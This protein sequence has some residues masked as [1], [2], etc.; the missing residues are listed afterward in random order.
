[1]ITKAQIRLIH[2][3][4]TRLGIEDNDYR[5]ILWVVA[6]VFSSKDLDQAGFADVIAY[7]EKLGFQTTFGGDSGERRRGM[8]SDKQASYI[9]RLW[10]TYTS[11]TGTEM[12][13]GKWLEHTF[14]VSSL[15][16]LPADQAPKAITA[17]LAMTRRPATRR[18]TA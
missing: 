12:T 16:F 6:R 15:R 9:R 2:V 1:M 17:L 8:A 5:A 14:K 10:G 13:L 7:F 18:E 11:G 3:A 4:K